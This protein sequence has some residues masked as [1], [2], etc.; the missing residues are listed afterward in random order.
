MDSG[1]G[2]SGRENCVERPH[3]HVM[4]DLAR[5][6]IFLEN[7]LLPD[8][9]DT[10]APY[11]KMRGF[12]RRT[13][14]GGAWELCEFM[15]AAMRDVWRT[16]LPFECDAEVEFGQLGLRYVVSETQN[17]PSGSYLLRSGSYMVDSESKLVIRKN[18]TVLHQGNF[19]HVGARDDG[20]ASPAKP[21]ELNNSTVVGP[22]YSST[23]MSDDDE[24]LV[25]DELIEANDFR[26]KA[27]QIRLYCEDGPAVDNDQDADM[28]DE[29]VQDFSVTVTDISASVSEV[30]V[31][32]DGVVSLRST[33]ISVSVRGIQGK[34]ADAK[35]RSEDSSEEHSDKE[36]LGSS[37]VSESQVC[38]LKGKFSLWL[39]RD[40]VNVAIRFLSPKQLAADPA[41]PE[42][43]LPWQYF[44]SKFKEQEIWKPLLAFMS[45]SSEDLEQM[46]VVLLISDAWEK[47]PWNEQCGWLIVD[48]NFHKKSVGWGTEIFGDWVADGVNT[49]LYGDRAFITRESDEHFAIPITPSFAKLFNPSTRPAEDVEAPSATITGPSVTNLKDTISSEVEESKVVAPSW[50]VRRPKSAKDKSKFRLTMPRGYEFPESWVRSQLMEYVDWC[51][52][53]RVRRGVRMMRP[54]IFDNEDQKLTRAIEWGLSRYHTHGMWIPEWVPI[55]DDKENKRGITRPFEHIAI[56]DLNFGF[57]RNPSEGILQGRG[58][59][60]TRELIKRALKHIHAKVNKDND[61]KEDKGGAFEDIF[62]DWLLPLVNWSGLPL[63]ANSDSK[64]SDLK[65][66]DPFQRGWIVAVLGRQLPLADVEYNESEDCKPQWD[67]G[68]MWD[69]LANTNALHSE[70]GKEMPVFKD[71]VIVV[72]SSHLLRSAGIKISHRLSWESTALDVVN[73][74]E[75]N[76]RLKPLMSFRHVVVRCG[77][78]GAV[79]I[80]PSDGKTEQVQKLFYDATANDEFFRESDPF[81]EGRALGCNSIFA[82][83]IFQALIECKQSESS[84]FQV[85][86]A[87]RQAIVDCQKVFENG[88]CDSFREDDP[89]EIGFDYARKVLFQKKSKFKER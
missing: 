69:V 5:L 84:E 63:E 77:Y 44:F 4:G 89:R 28:D 25:V 19:Q 41:I 56:M 52:K 17:A 15:R 7:S 12:V 74:I 36:S 8:H 59:F 23:P 66:K 85:G 35:S 80:T 16:N 64:N 40:R 60:D 88:Y 27:M 24:L 68:D 50:N 72:V 43:F 76:P 9:F 71:R 58:K 33:D 2:V 14:R 18:G 47:I 20:D 65:I 13:L 83:R 32:A 26:S 82:A 11:R 46:R 1:K 30:S 51:K 10:L 3:I 73:Q 62:P 22:L 61:G 34:V 87:I 6:S 49:F 78:T 55:C 81:E 79:L 48:Q 67:E 38:A 37:E 42:R 21:E 86:K 53:L 57:R 45:E 39:A 31:E 29:V 75:N 70:S 54:S